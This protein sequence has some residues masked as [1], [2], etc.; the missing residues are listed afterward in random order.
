MVN[1]K[2]WGDFEEIGSVYRTRK[3]KARD[4]DEQI[5]YTQFSCPYGC[6][7][8]VELPAANVSS[9][10]ATVCRTH[11][12]ECTGV[13]SNG[14]QARDDP[15][16]AD[17]RVAK[18]PR[19]DDQQH[20]LHTDR[21]S[22]LAEA[23]ERIEGKTAE[24]AQLASSNDR[25]VSKNEA[26]TGRVHALEEQ[27]NELRIEMKSM[28]DGLEFQKKVVQEQLKWM[29]R[30]CGHLGIDPIPHE[31]PSVISQ[32]KSLSGRSKENESLRASNAAKDA[33]ITSLKRQLKAAESKP[34]SEGDVRAWSS[35]FDKSAQL[36]R[37]AKT[38]LGSGCIP[39]AALADVFKQAV[40][41]A[42]RVVDP[43]WNKHGT[44]HA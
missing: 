25:L 2:K 33:E 11:L 32:I 10:K 27:M 31:A 7:V 42:P 39:D 6:A 38:M 20:F 3:Y 30:V 22:E 23:R 28:R 43:H 36:T 21:L 34:Y 14:T 26:L 16:V 18:M 9:K 35:A 5:E 1:N 40:P 19:V 17:A 41:T 44:K 37:A 4:G 8:A 13:S 29:S 12:M 15:R 24:C